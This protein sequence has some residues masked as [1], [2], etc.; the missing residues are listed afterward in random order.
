GRALSLLPQRRPTT[1][2]PPWEQKRPRG[3]LAE[4]R[5]EQGRTAD[6]VGD[7]LLD[8][9]WIEQHKFGAR[10]RLVGL[11][12][13]QHDAVVTGHRLRVHPVALLQPGRDR[14]RPGAVS[15]AA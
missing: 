4:P 11:G 5:R 3:T 14:K 13:P 8:L 15:L 9:G 6:L 10:R 7:H 12:Q 1:W 2:I